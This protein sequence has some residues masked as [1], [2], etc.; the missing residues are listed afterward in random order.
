[1]Y[2][3]QMF[4]GLMNRCRDGF[5][6]FTF[7]FFLQQGICMTLYKQLNMQHSHSNRSYEDILGLPQH[8]TSFSV[9][10]SWNTLVFLTDYA[11]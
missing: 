4:M 10:I 2:T 9:L 11:N 3:K 1:M 6:S 7:L 8:H 5:S